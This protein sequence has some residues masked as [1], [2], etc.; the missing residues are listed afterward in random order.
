MDPGFDYPTEK[1]L[2]PELT[3]TYTVQHKLETGAELLKLQETFLGMEMSDD[4]EGMKESREVVVAVE[5]PK[6]K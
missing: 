2:M 3:E 4:D 6:T 1:K 5:I